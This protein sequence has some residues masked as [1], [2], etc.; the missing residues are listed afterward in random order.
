MLMAAFKIKIKSCRHASV[1]HNHKNQTVIPKKLGRWVKCKSK[2]NAD[3]Q[4]LFDLHSIGYC[5]KTRDLMFKMIHFAVLCKYT[6]IL[7]LV[8]ARRSKK[9]A[10]AA[11]LPLCYITFSSNN[12]RWTLSEDTDCWSS[13]SENLSFSSLIYDLSRST[14]QDLCCCI[15]CFIECGLAGTSRESL[16]KMPSVCTSAFNSQI[17]FVN[18]KYIGCI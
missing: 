3:S 15:L 11:H 1:V 16:E 12:T 8:L 9:V 5:I 14:V 17:E 18:I 13:E 7:N 4:I 10:I 6:L 2:Q